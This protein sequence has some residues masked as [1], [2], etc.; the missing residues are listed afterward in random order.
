MHLTYD[1][2]FIGVD[3]HRQ[4]GRLQP[5]SPGLLGYKH[6]EVP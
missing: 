3:A 6:R 2:P 4:Q 1:A 5:L